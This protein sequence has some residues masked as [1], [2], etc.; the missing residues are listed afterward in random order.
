VLEAGEPCTSVFTLAGGTSEAVATAVLDAGW[1][2]AI[3]D[4]SKSLSEK[5]SLKWPN[6]GNRSHKI[7]TSSVVYSKD[8]DCQ[9][10]IPIEKYRSINNAP[11]FGVR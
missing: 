2:S 11:G 9:H 7:I 8:F 10:H 3:C 1:N 4:A 5:I 6:S